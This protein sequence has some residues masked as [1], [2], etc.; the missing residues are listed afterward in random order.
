[1]YVRQLRIPNGVRAESGDRLIL[2]IVDADDPAFFDRGMIL[3]ALD[4]I[5]DAIGRGSRVLVHCNEGRS[6]SP[7]IALLYMASRAG[8][9]P[10]SSLEDAEKAFG[11]LY[12]SYAPNGGIRGHLAQNWDSYCARPDEG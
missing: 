12:P 3:Q 2:N 5:D 6:R 7:S 10:T 8:A 1:M 9:L 11:D 4:F